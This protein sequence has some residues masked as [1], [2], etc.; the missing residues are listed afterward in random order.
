MYGLVKQQHLEDI[1]QA[2]C[3]CLGHGINVKAVDLLL[4]TAG[5]E[6]NRGQFKDTTKY[7]GMGITQFDKGTFYDV[8]ERTNKQR[9]QKVMQYFGIDINLI[10]WEDLRYNPLLSM[11][12]TRLK[13][14]LI[15]DA[16]PQTLEARAA[17]WKKWYNGGGKGTVDHYVF[18]N[19]DTGVRYA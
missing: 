10:K 4:E 5:A 6:T 9:R 8:K 18:A 7:A 19:M 14:N 11:L 3:D 13:Y 17:Y 2:V 12:F 16:I 15:P 1:A